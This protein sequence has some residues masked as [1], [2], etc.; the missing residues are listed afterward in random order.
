MH[1]LEGARESGSSPRARGTGRSEQRRRVS[2][3]FIPARAGNGVQ[4]EW[5]G[6]PIAVHPRARGE[7]SSGDISEPG[8]LGSS[9]RARGTASQTI[10]TLNHLGSS[11]RARGTG[12]H[13]PGRR[14]RRRFIP[15]RA[16]NG[17]T[18]APSTSAA[19]VHPRARGER[20]GRLQLGQ[21][22][23]V[24]PRARGERLSFVMWRNFAIGSSPRARGTVFTTDSWSCGI[25]FI[26][27][28]A[29][30]GRAFGSP[31]PSGTVH[32]RARGERMRGTAV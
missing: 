28:R 11:P 31:R 4:L 7:R 16:G 9:P 24:H 20:A 23:S 32:P 30:N 13:R 25:R 14:L 29:G 15:A 12:R 18:A 1:T 5:R 3:R 21:I 22:A 8:P 26:P 19:S 10:E 2:T 6:L 27:A 17:Y